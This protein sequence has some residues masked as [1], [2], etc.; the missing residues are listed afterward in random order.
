MLLYMAFDICYTQWN[1]FVKSGFI[2]I[3]TSKRDNI[4]ICIMLVILIIK[5]ER[6]FIPTTTYISFSI[7]THYHWESYLHVILGSEVFLD[8]HHP[9]INQCITLQNATIS[10]YIFLQFGIYPI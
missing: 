4:L 7:K 2:C 9:S 1:D 3:N 8:V 5:D 10:I 6:D